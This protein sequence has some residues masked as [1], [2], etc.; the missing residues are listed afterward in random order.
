[1]PLLSSYLQIM[2]NNYRNIA[3]I[4]GAVVLFAT[5]SIAHEYGW[6]IPPSPAPAPVANA[7]VPMPDV[8]EE[9]GSED[10]IEHDDSEI[11]FLDIK[12]QIKKSY[13]IFGDLF[14]PNVDVPPP[15]LI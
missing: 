12:S 5:F 8:I 7:Q 15:D 3:N 4:F 6:L 9:H 13:M 14:I 2:K 10:E 11:L 1:M